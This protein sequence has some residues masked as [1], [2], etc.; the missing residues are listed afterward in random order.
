MPISCRDVVAAAARAIG[1]TVAVAV[2]VTVV[3]V[4]VAAVLAAVDVEQS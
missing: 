4:L 1:P 2:S 3:V